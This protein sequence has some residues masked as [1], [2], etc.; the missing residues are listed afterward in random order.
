M[1]NNKSRDYEEKLSEASRL[2]LEN[3]RKTNPHAARNHKNGKYDNSYGAIRK[4]RKR[5]HFIAKVLD[6]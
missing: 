2:W 1:K 6:F 4:M 3:H 5:D